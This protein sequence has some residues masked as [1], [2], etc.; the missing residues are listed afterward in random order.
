MTAATETS[1][2]TMSATI[3]VTHAFFL[4][5][6]SLRQRH[7]PFVCEWFHALPIFSG[8]DPRPPLFHSPPG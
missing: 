2:R 3:D 1:G 4:K 6:S 7:L 8:F 5:P